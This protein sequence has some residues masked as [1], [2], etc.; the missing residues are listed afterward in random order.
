MAAPTSKSRESARW[1]W[2]FAPEAFLAAGVLS[3]CLVAWAMTFDFSAPIRAAL[4]ALGVLAPTLVGFVVRR[5]H[6]RLLAEAAEYAA[7]FGQ[8]ERQARIPARLGSRAFGEFAALLNRIADSIVARE[9]DFELLARATGDA[10]WDCD[11]ESGDVIWWQGGRR[12]LGA[13]AEAFVEPLGWWE[14]RLHP[15][16]RAAV[17][18]G[19]ADIRAGRQ[20]TWSA[21]YRFRHADGTYRWFWDK[22]AVVRDADGAPLRVVGAMTD[23]SDRKAAEEMLRHVE[24]RQR[25][26]ITA[27][28]SIVWRQDLTSRTQPRNEAWEEYTGQTQEEEFGEGWLD[29]VHPEDRERL[30]HAWS[31]AVRDGAAYQVDIRLRGRDGAYRWMSARGAPVRNEAGELVEFIG[32]YEDVDDYYVAR[33]ELRDRTRALAERV[34]EMRC[35]HA[36]TVICQRDD[37]AAPKILAGVAL[38]LASAMARPQAAVCAIRWGGTTVRSPDYIEPAVTLTAPLEVDGA[39]VGE[40]M[41]GYTGRPDETEFLPEER[42]LLETTANL[43]GQMVARRRDRDRLWQM[44]NHDA[45]TGL[46]N[47]RYFQEKLEAEGGKPGTA[48]LLVDLD[49]FKEV[50][51]TLGHDVGDALLEAVAERLTEAAGEKASAARLG[52]DEFALL[53]HAADEHAARELADSVL[54]RLRRPV[55]LA[56]QMTSVAFSAGLAVA[57]VVGSSAKEL[58]KNADIALYFAKT[59][60]RNALVSYQPQMSEAVERRLAI[61]S[62]V[63]AALESDEFVPFYQPKVD[64]R[65]GA[66]TGFEALLRWMHPAGM[67]GPSAVG[68]AF[69]DHELALAL[70]NR[71]LDK[72]LADIGAWRA[73]GLAF[74]HVALNTAAAEFV[75]FDLAGHLLARLAAAGLPPSVLGIE[76][77]ETV[78]LGREAEAI[79]PMLLRLHAAGV[80]VALDDFG[81]GYA[82]LTHLQQFPVDIIKIDQ[83]FIRSLS[84]DAGSQAIVAAVVGLGRSL[85]VAVIAEGV[86]TVEH[87]ELL[88]SAGCGQ[89]QG[90]VF[91]RPM[92]AADVPGFLATWPGLAAKSAWGGL[93]AA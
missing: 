2:A 34:K 27:V 72:I 20:D 88:K 8:G 84:A 91:A 55:V 50:N 52:G 82:S 85:G 15:D 81:T 46:P 44:A 48:L 43:V 93:S 64:L 58:L 56:G 57:P 41:L 69:E 19:S 78:L 36:I 22:A 92:P 90:F 63:R 1:S 73:S 17:L 86:E 80:G 47:R 66:I 5:H 45:L 16:D 21:E 40:I 79:G 42:Q 32:L 11:L 30:L 62:E 13:H 71:M 29:A 18:A 9:V 53:A 23:I 61:C 7:R 38:V 70:S 28:S 24:R 77:T 3:A 68:P 12:V 51:D 35:L 4:A 83:T 33:E 59:R 65:S 31:N 87:V 10:V 60:G 26:L 76:V 25:A 75:G 37:V 14:E 54:A 39:A 89:A 67:R 74:G 49:H 6:I